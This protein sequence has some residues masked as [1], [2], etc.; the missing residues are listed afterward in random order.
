MYI[1]MP[2]KDRY[3]YIKQ[4]ILAKKHIICDMPYTLEIEKQAELEKLAEISMDVDIDCGMTIYGTNGKISVPDD[5][6]RVGYFKMKTKD[7]DK[8]KHYSS[9]FEGNGFRYLIQAILQEIRAEQSDATHLT[10][11]EGKA[12]LKVVN[13]ICVRN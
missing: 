3:T 7:D 12:I 11:I 1:K 9:N 10:S 2:L 13:D 8:S 5:W 4:A 6:W